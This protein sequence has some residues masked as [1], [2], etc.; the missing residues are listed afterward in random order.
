MLTHYVIR[1][2]EMKINRYFILQVAP[3]CYLDCLTYM[4]GAYWY[5]ACEMLSYTARELAEHFQKV[6]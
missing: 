6:L 4:L 3:Y 1:T 2:E 5:M